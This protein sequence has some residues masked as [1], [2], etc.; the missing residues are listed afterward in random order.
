MNTRNSILAAC[1]VG[2]ALVVSAE[3]AQGELITHNYSG[4]V[5]EVLDLDGIFGASV[6]PGDRVSGS[7]T[8]E[9]TTPDTRISPDIGVYEQALTAWTTNVGDL[10]FSL[11]SSFQSIGVGDGFNGSDF[12]QLF[13]AL[14]P[15][16]GLS[17]P[18][19]NLLVR[20]TTEAVFS[21]DALRLEPVDRSQ[22]EIRRT[23]DFG[24]F[25]RFGAPRTGI[26]MRIT[27]FSN[28]GEYL[29]VSIDIKPDS[30]PNII[31]LSSA[32]VIPV[33]IL[34]SETFDALTVDENTI[35][36]A[37]AGVKV[38]GGSS[39]HMCHEEDINDDGLDDLIC[40]VETAEFMIEPGEGTADLTADTFDGVPVRGTDSIQIVPD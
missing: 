12:Y 3:S 26:R 4:Y 14:Q 16:H 32:G 27:S 37:S 5:L 11:G 7:Y 21:S 1:T 31:N 35:F 2:L 38:A 29:E 8:F 40:Q 15:S 30:I 9:S 28:P 24:I 22:F 23:A 25:E 33:A 6:M 17:N 20:D 13:G 18:V 19:G 34:S 39:R 10:S 36:F